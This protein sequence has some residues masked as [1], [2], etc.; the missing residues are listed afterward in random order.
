MFVDW[1]NFHKPRADRE[2][3][4]L[5]VQ[6]SWVWQSWCWCIKLER[7][8][9]NAT[10]LSIH[11]NTMLHL[12]NLRL[13]KNNCS[14][15]SWGLYN[16]PIYN[17]N[18]IREPGAFTSQLSLDPLTSTCMLSRPP[19]HPRVKLFAHPNHGTINN[20]NG[21]RHRWRGAPGPSIGR[22]NGFV[23]KPVRPNI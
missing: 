1:A 16:S 18:W 7:L 6:E 12:K 13:C 20:H 23:R 22:I 15:S 2:E 4:R 5:T 10:R 9:E 14:S 21:S 3:I 11:V 19:S 8:R 17:F